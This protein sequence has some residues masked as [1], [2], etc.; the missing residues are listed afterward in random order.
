MVSFPT[1]L[2]RPFQLPV[3]L[4]MSSPTFLGEDPKGPILRARA[5]ET[6]TS[7][8][9]YLR[10][11]TLSP[12]GSNLGGVVEAA[13]VRMTDTED[14]CAFTPSKLKAKQLKEFILQGKGCIRRP[15]AILPRRL[16]Q[17]CGRPVPMADL[18]SFFQAL[19]LTRAGLYLASTWPSAP[20]PPEG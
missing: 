2:L 12:L 15:V 5:G 16:S 1:V 7:P 20:Y 11:V 17:Q 4:M 18:T 19:P 9:V 3:A 6:P 10:C 13:G 8:L 14:R